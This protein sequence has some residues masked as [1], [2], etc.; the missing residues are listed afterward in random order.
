[1]LQSESS[2][3]LILRPIAWDAVEAITQSER[4]EDWAADFPDEGDVVIAGLLQR[5]GGPDRLAPVWGH[6]QI[7]ERSS[8][9]VVG[10]A[11]FFGPPEEGRAEIGYGVVPSRQGR[12]YATDAVR[13]LTALG[14]THGALEIAAQTDL[15]NRASQRVL[16]KAGF[17]LLNENE[18]RIY[19]LKRPR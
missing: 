18:Q 7:V 4:L 9:L 10:G 2:S 12:G 15:E 6:H 19:H 16:E 17:Q 14:W 11:G 8:G 5:R 13:L 1:M 3:P